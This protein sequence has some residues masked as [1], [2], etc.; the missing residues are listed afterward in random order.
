MTEDDCHTRDLESAHEAYG[1]WL[2]DTGLFDTEENEATFLAGFSYGMGWAEAL[3][4]T[5]S[6]RVRIMRTPTET[7][8]EPVI[9]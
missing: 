5:D 3:E 9:Q 2:E 6:P 4:E 8:A 1:A 7:N